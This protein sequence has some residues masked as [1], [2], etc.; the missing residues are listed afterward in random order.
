MLSSKANNRKS[1]L[2]LMIIFSV[3][4]S[5]IG[6]GEIGSV[7]CRL[8]S[9]FPVRRRPSELSSWRRVEVRWTLS[10]G[11]LVVVRRVIFVVER[12][13]ELPFISAC[14]LVVSCSWKV[15]VVYCLRVHRSVAAVWW[16]QVCGFVPVAAVRSQVPA[17]HGCAPL[18]LTAA[19]PL[20]Q[21]SPFYLLAEKTGTSSLYWSLVSPACFWLVS[22]VLMV[23]GGLLKS[24]SSQCVEPD[25]FRI[26]GPVAAVASVCSFRVAFQASCGVNYKPDLGGDCKAVVCIWNS[27]LLLVLRFIDSDG[28]KLCGVHR[29]LATPETTREFPA[30]EATRRT[31]HFP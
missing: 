21:P 29:E 18:F 8:R 10:R 16:S 13:T 12:S 3:T 20:F 31:S 28:Y 25:C 19:L 14:G 15:V 4:A 26:S 1:C 7:Y 9:G 5:P 11:R 23:L 6:S 30:S 17:V 24:L 22:W 2:R 27:L